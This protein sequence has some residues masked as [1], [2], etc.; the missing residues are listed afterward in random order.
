MSSV[1]AVFKIIILLV[2]SVLLTTP[3]IFFLFFHKG[4]KSYYIPWMWHKGVCAILGL[5]TEIKGTPVHGRQLIYISNHLSYLDIPVIGSCLRASFIAKED[6]AHWPVI[7][8]LA[9]VQQTAFI[10]RSSHK[11]KKVANALDQMVKDGKSLILFPEGT[12]S[13]GTSVL[14]FKSSLFS[15]AQP[16]DL[17]HPVAI[18]PFVLELL[19]VNDQPLTKESRDLY[20]W[21]GDMDFAPHIWVFLK[22]KGATIRLTFLDVITPG[23]NQDRKELCKIVESQISSGL[24]AA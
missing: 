13:A 10:S 12:S 21:Y 11:A 23:D 15:L 2:W 14:P 18:Q 22:N 5:K 9:T 17:P 24:P 4:K 3:Q 20:A 1:I 19:D 16:K 8:F 7:G 6:I